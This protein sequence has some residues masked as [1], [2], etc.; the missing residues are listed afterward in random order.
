MTTIRLLWGE[1]EFLLREAALDALGGVQAAS[2]EG[3]SWAGGET[4]DLATPS[5]FGE[6]RALLVTDCQELTD[7]GVRELR[8]YLQGPAPDATLILT[9]RGLRA[10][11]P[12]AK[13]VKEAGGEVDKVEVT[14]KELTN[15]LV[16]RARRRD[17]D[18]KPPAINA[19]VEILGEAPAELDQALDQLGSAFPGVP[20]T[21]QLVER[22]FRGLGDAKTWE[23]CDRAFAGD[24]SGAVRALASI[25]ASRGDPL[26]ILGGIA[27]RVRDLEKVASVPEGLSGAEAARA[28]GLRFEWQLKRYRDTARRYPPGAL[29]S[30]HLGVADADRALKNGAS[31]DV[32]LPMLLAR[33]AGQIPADAPIEVGSVARALR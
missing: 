11:P 27:A 5:L 12:I 21:P 17:L 6:P 29:A 1:D 8:A 19:L 28:A 30:L 23:V 3:G 33:I 13:D 9:G 18:I 2:V 4:A 26:M 15:W 24:L 10:A 22:Q 25:L 16:K 32:I 7:E 14:K 31:G 20:I